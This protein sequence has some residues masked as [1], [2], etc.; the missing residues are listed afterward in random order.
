MAQRAK[1]ESECPKSISS[2][3]FAADHYAAGTRGGRD[4]QRAAMLYEKACTNPPRQSFESEYGREACVLAALY[5]PSVSDAER[6]KLFQRACDKESGEETRKSRFGCTAVSCVG[7]DGKACI[8][9]GL[10]LWSTGSGWPSAVVLDKSGAHREVALE[11]IEKGCALGAKECAPA[12]EG[13]RKSALAGLQS[14][15][16]AP[17]SRRMLPKIRKALDARCQAGDAQT[18]FGLAD[19][20]KNGHGGSADAG[21]AKDLVKK[22]CELGYSDACIAARGAP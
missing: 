19:M 2:C 12:L 11:W 13:F 16:T 3:V 1:T 17:F 8:Q 21:G 20:L 18:C 15:G 9:L 6:Q 22:A 10:A 4:V 7:G 5:A 14:D